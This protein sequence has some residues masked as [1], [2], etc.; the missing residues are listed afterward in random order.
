MVTSPSRLPSLPLCSVVELEYELALIEERLEACALSWP[1]SDAA[2]A[3]RQ[4][5]RAV[6]LRWKAGLTAQREA[7]SS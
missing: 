4:G 6:L 1:V 7:A 5:W 3:R 2:E